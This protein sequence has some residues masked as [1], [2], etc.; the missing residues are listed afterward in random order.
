MAGPDHI[1]FEDWV[2]WVFDRT[3]RDWVWRE[4]DCERYVDDDD[5]FPWL[6][7]GPLQ[8]QHFIDLHHD[9]V[10]QL[11]KYNDDQV[12]WGLWNL[13]SGVCD[14]SVISGH[15]LPLEMHSQ[16]IRSLLPMMR[17]I[18]PDRVSHVDI[19]QSNDI[20]CAFYMFWDL[21][22]IWPFGTADREANSE[23]V[24]I[25]YAEMEQALYLDHPVAQHHALHG[26]GHFYVGHPWR[27]TSTVD[28]W[29]NSKPDLLPFIRE[30]AQQ[31]RVGAIM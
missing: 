21:A 8:A 19:F 1:S 31:A 24:D 28:C 5:A 29:L 11:S 17:Q 23:L 13:Y 2:V 3:N 22:G 10:R 26:L 9:S 6:L 25:C 14:I 27:T 12:G 4:L 30:Y 16:M 7:N 18:L 15:G 20:S